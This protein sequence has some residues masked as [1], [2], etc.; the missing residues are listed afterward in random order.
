M[1]AGVPQLNKTEVWRLTPGVGGKEMQ[2]VHNRRWLPEAVVFCLLI[3]ITVMK[4]FLNGDTKILISHTN[5]WV[6]FLPPSPSLQVGTS[7]QCT[8]CTQITILS[9]EILDIC[10]S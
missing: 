8:L 3:I 9:M 7:T 10:G 5:V 1:V 6:S 4:T 2:P